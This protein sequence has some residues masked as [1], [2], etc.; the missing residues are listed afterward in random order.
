LEVI[1]TVSSGD[2]TSLFWKNKRYSSKDRV[3]EEA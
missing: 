2:D 1:T 3:D